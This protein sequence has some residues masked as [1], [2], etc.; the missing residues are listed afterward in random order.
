MK[1][2]GQLAL[3]PDS[4]GASGSGSCE[5]VRSEGNLSLY[6]SNLT[7]EKVAISLP[8]NSTLLTRKRECIVTISKEENAGIRGWRSY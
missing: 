3:H 5:C 1:E 2:P 6:V 8:Q 4:G 7:V